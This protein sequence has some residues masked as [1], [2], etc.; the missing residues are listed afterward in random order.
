MLFMLDEVVQLGVDGFFMATPA[1]R[2]GRIDH[3][4][5]LTC[6]QKMPMFCEP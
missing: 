6:F 5:H 2:T 1:R 3:C 4:L